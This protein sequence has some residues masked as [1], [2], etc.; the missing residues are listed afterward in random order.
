MKVLQILP[1]LRVG[2]VETG[3]VDFARWLI[4]HGHEGLVVSNGGELVSD[5]TKVGG[6]HFQ[7]PVH[8]KNLFTMAWSFQ[9]LVKILREEKPDVVHARSRVPAWIAYFACRK[10]GVPFIT[11]CHGYYSKHLFS[12]VMGWAKFV[13]VP[14]QVIGHHMIE[15]FGVLP[16]SIRCIPRSVDLRRFDIPRQSDASKA[17]ITIAL[18]GR[19]TPLKGHEYFL[20]A[21]ARVA[22]KYPYVKAWVIGDA[23][24]NKESYKEGLLALT[25]HL[26]LTEHV[27][28]LGNRKDIPEL[29]S[30][31]DV[32]VLS[33][34][35][36]E[37]FGRVILEAQ[38]AGVP[39]VATKVGGVV[40]LI[41]DTETGL[42]VSP[43]QPEEMAQ[44]IMKI[45]EDKALARQMVEN[46]K[47]KIL[48]H[49]T[50]DHMAGQ[51]MK[52]YE[53]IT[54]QQNILVIKFSAVGDV[55]LITPSL[56]ALR[57]KYPLAKIYCLVAKNCREILQTCPYVDDIIIYDPQ[58]KHRHWWK[59]WKLGKILR[60]YNFNKVIDFQNN[61][62][63]HLLS[64]LSFCPERYGYK[65]KKWGFLL[66]QGIKDDE[67]P[68]PPVAHQFRVLEKL[69]IALGTDVELELWSAKPDTRYVQELLEGCW[70]APETR[71]VGIN[72]A[73]SRRW[74]S[75]NW[76][77]EYIV[78]LCDILASK[79]IR[80]ILTGLE[81]DQELAKD[82]LKLA[83]SKPVDFTGKTNIL[84]L[85]A[86]IKKC[87]VF[88]TPDS[89]PMH[90]AAAVK[91]PF[92]ALF[93]PTDSFRHI[94]PS[95]SYRVI[96]LKPECAPCYKG[97]CPI[98]THICMKNITVEKVAQNIED[99]MPKV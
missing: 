16:E 72:I 93:G 64:F 71:L 73:A 80:V 95:G 39:V 17:Q 44:A 32:L 20:R 87:D 50:L 14:S 96:E 89:A 7:V 48:S 22:R 49:Y 12:R 65:N 24:A 82:I 88:L 76:P 59:L 2:G 53:E 29:L 34:V 47:K 84:Q 52:V 15:D 86:L 99:L 85:A 60:R 67:G 46:A 79:N 54:K 6:K 97:D 43:K 36:Q 4:E 70:M 68:M 38:A 35:T 92:V 69:G 41:D 21:I 75:K 77:K 56:K 74:L 30:K 98:K 81:K 78:K 18:V 51:T 27:E 3:T 11:T 83:K 10:T 28:F 33:T 23:P 58:H 9:K 13:I 91:T 25:K 8:Q 31:V 45:L 40:E 42:L 37:S 90:V 1:E 62:R 57:T 55:L 94:P 26:G 19:I 66:S 61:R 63:S 5:L